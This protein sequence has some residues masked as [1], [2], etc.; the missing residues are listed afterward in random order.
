MLSET[1][2]VPEKLEPELMVTFL[3]LNSWHARANAVS[4]PGIN[5][6]DLKLIPEC[7]VKDGGVEG[8]Y[9]DRDDYLAGNYSYSYLSHVLRSNA[10]WKKECQT[11]GQEHPHHRKFRQTACH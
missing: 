4:H 2:L 10:L 3:G 9:D 8:K 11:G 1:I 7:V 5:S 6:S